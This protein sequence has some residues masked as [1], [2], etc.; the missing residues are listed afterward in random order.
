MSRKRLG[1]K[2][3]EGRGAVRGWGCGDASGRGSKSGYASEFLYL[4]LEF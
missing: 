4:M 1:D 3:M 2:E